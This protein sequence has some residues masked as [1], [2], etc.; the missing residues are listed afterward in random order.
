MFF[1]HPNPI[2]EILKA[3]FFIANLIKRKPKHLNNNPQ[4][5]P[6][7]E[8]SIPHFRSRPL[9][10]PRSSDS[11]NRRQMEF[12]PNLG[13]GSSRTSAH[14]SKINP[15]NG[16]RLLSPGEARV[17]AERRNIRRGMPSEVGSGCTALAAACTEPTTKFC[18]S[19]LFF[20]N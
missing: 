5:H 7:K 6:L 8:P 10:I 18:R 3:H 19:Y 12:D 14:K 20:A 2:S 11:I 13:K 9:E 4:M 1:K 16:K 15:A 17:A